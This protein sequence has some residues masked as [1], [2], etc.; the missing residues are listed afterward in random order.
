V[1]RIGSFIYQGIVSALSPVVSW[2]SNI[3]QQ[4][5][6]V[7]LG[8]GHSLWNAGVRIVQMFVQG[9]Q[10]AFD[11]AVANFQAQLQRVRNL[12]PS[13]DAKTGPLSDISRTGGGMMQTFADGISAHPVVSA[14][15]S[16]L[17][18][19]A[20]VASGGGT[21]SPV[22]VGAGGMGDIIF[23]PTYTIEVGAGTT[24]EVVNDLIEQL[25]ERDRELLDVISQ[26]Q[27]R[28]GRATY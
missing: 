8:I 9:F 5:V 10:A 23:Q 4:V 11:G 24:K 16:A 26:A 17:S 6:N 1:G 3:M 12:L 7:V 27:S 20:N 21:V 14:L 2:V 22:P 25:R 19:V 13:S 15:D 18:G 28:I